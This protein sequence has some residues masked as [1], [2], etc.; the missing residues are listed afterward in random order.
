[1]RCSAPTE[2]PKPSARRAD[3]ADAAFR[4]RHR[5]RIF[6]QDVG[7]GERVDVGPRRVAI[8]GA[9]N[10]EDLLGAGRSGEPRRDSRLDRRPIGPDEEFPRRGDEGG[11]HEQGE[12]ARYRHVDGLRR[13]KVG[14][15]AAV[16]DHVDER[17]LVRA[18]LAEDV[19]AQVLQ[20]DALAR[21]A[22]GL[23]GAGE[24]ILIAKMPS[25]CCAT[26][27]A[28]FFGEAPAP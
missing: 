2:P 20:S 7:G 19:A 22:A 26:M 8:V 16:G 11:P 13:G 4:L 10:I 14:I 5:T 12:L 18:V 17:G 21:G 25:T 15:A 1:M 27:R 6:V 23:P 9:E 28:N 3:L 24:T